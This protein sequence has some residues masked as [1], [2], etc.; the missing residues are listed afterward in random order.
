[1][2][3]SASSRSVAVLHFSGSPTNTGTM[4]V[5]FRMTAA[6]H[7]VHADR[8]YLVGIS[9]G[10]VT[11]GEVTDAVDRCHIAVHGIKRLKYD[12]LR[13]VR[14]G[15]PQQ[16]LQ[17]RHVVMAEDLFLALRLAHALDHGIVV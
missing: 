1:M 5:P 9:H 3:W 8:V 7:A 12:Q 10:V 13:P 15:C 17:M 16:L 6:A 2:P 4:C 14:I 11:L